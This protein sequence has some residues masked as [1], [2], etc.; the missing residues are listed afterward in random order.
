MPFAIYDPNYDGEYHM[1]PRAAPGLAN[2]AAT[3]L[4]LLGFDAPPDYE[5][6]LIEF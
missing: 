3:L 5:P 2:V 1:A 4:N 6:S